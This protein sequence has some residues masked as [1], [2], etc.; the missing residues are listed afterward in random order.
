[1]EMNIKQLYDTYITKL[2]LTEK[3]ELL[4]LLM[5]STLELIRK[6]NDHDDHVLK[7]DELNTPND[8]ELTA[9]QKQLLKGPVMPDEDYK[10]YEEKKKH[11]SQWR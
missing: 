3:L 4:E 6:E 7:I 5:Q 10:L 1:M 2:K 11:F 8:Q 9:F